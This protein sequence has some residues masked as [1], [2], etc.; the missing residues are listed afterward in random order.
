MHI[1]IFIHHIVCGDMFILFIA[2]IIMTSCCHAI[3][4]A[5]VT[6]R[7]SVTILHMTACRVQRMSPAFLIQR[8]PARGSAQLSAGLPSTYL[9]YPQLT[10]HLSLL[11]LNM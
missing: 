3:V 4:P 2:V 10:G 1:K 6:P 5:L 11:L 7:D 9:Q 8:I